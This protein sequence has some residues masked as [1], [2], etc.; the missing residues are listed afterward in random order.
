MG[1]SRYRGRVTRRDGLGASHRILRPKDER[2]RFAI[3][4]LDALWT[5]YRSR[6][7]WV[8]VYERVL[9]RAGGAFV[10]DHVAFRTFASQRPGSGIFTVARLFEALGWEPAAC[11]R[12]PDKHLRSIHYEHPSPGFPKIFVSELRLWEL[13][14]AARRILLRLLAERRREPSEGFLAALRKPGEL[15]AAGRRSL[16][17]AADRHFRELPWEVPDK[18]A[19]LALDRESQFAAWTA[20]HGNEVNHFTISI[21]SHG[22]ADLGDIEKTVAA[23][24]AAGVP[25]KD[26]IEGARGSILRQ[27]A[28]AAAVIPARVR[29]GGRK[30]AMP[31]PYAYFELA[32]RGETVDPRTGKRARFEGF[33]GGQATNLFEMTRRR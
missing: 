5:R 11:Y 4:L 20:L 31:W 23:L 12:F 26:A 29:V 27:S 18:R 21:N 1:P 9:A 6:V 3:D 13:S 24:R 19:V 32:E 8:R 15:G 2:E 28:T 17:A 16:L 33:L 30:A 10:N 22:V 25:M 7:E 14:A